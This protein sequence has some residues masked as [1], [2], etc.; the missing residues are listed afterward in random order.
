MLNRKFTKTRGP[1]I[2]VFDIHAYDGLELSAE[3]ARLA[4]EEPDKIVKCCNGV[5]SEVGI[6]GNL[7]YHLIP[8]TIWF[9]NVTCC[10]DIHDVDYNYP[11]FFATREEAFK[12]KSDA[13]L[14][15]YNNLVTHI[16]RNTTNWMLRRMRLNRA[17]AYYL[18]VSNAGQMSFLDG[19]TIGQ[20][21]WK[22][23]TKE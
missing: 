17:Y 10:S 23:V 11:L 3:F 6:L 12:Y 13:D 22:G 15:L 21:V 16:K 1:S 8:N 14:R 18:A 4:K 20:T 19:K 9:L 7:S 2:T 5:G